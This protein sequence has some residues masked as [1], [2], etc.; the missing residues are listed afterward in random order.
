MKRKKETRPLLKKGIIFYLLSSTF[1]A[2]VL[3]SYMAGN[4]ISSAMDT[5]G[6]TF[7]LSSCFAHSALV[8]LSLFLIFYLPFSLLK[9]GRVAAV[10][11]TASISLLAM[12]TFV[13]LQVYRI[14]RFHINGFILNLLTGPAAGD[15]FD[16]DIKLVLTECLLLL[17][18]LG[19]T[20]GLWVAS[21]KLTD[22]MKRWHLAAGASFLAVCLLVS[23]IT[24]IYGAFIVKPSV[25]QSARLLPYYFPLSASSLMVKMG[26]ERH[27]M[28]T[29]GMDNSGELSYPLKPL[30]TEATPE[31]PDIVFILIDSWSKQALTDTCM[32]YLRQLAQ[33]EQWYTN[34]VSCSNGTQFAVFGMF[35]GLQP[36]YWTAFESGRFSPVLIDRLIQLGYDFKAYPSASLV[37]PPFNRVLFQNVPHLRLDTRGGSSFERDMVIKNDFVADLPK[38][39]DS[40]SPFFSFVFF[41]LLHAY[42]LPKELLNRFQPSWEYGDFTKLHNEMDPTP[43]WNLY[44]N[45]AYQTDLMVKEIIEKLKELG[46]YENTLVF[47]TGD[48]AQ[49]YNENHKNYWG[50]NSNFSTYQIGVPLIVHVP[51]SQATAHHHRTT[52]YDF[53]PTLMHDYLG[54]QNPIED[55]C[56]GRLLSDSTARL[57]HFVG[58]ELRFAFL[59]EDDTI[60][61]KEGAGWI[62]ATDKHL[63]PV[64]DYRINAKGFDKA[65]KQLNRFFKTS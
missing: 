34:H 6:W 10:L 38:L 25:M 50:H 7:F 33:E 45:S 48:H 59:L 5:L 28:D 20:V 61:T 13:N 52:H 29:G 22:L 26:I 19:V 2:L 64:K 60:L 49:E 56:A 1:V 35:T 46:M 41:D 3:M 4:L 55:Y 42:S 23:N 36:Y 15:I 30:Q 57:W 63:N 17:L 14:Y 53:V 12:T 9:S 40:K 11:Y 16:F 37:S 39:R 32:P 27:V 44:R 8:C 62:E 51:D 18:I 54:V 47:I 43:F 58:N 65:I 21:C 24:H 31:C